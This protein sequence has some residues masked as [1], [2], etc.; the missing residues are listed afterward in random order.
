MRGGVV[1]LNRWG[2]LDQIIDPQ[3]RI[4]AFS[5]SP[6]VDKGRM[7]TILNRKVPD[8]Y[9]RQ[10]RADGTYDALSEATDVLGDRRAF[11][12]ADG[13]C[14]GGDGVGQGPAGQRDRALHRMRALGDRG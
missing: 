1:Q 13:Q 3:S 10:L 11:V 8:D 6:E 4:L 9:Q 5:T 14:A 12:V 2:L 7:A